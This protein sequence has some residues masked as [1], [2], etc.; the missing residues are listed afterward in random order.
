MRAHEFVGEANYAGNQ[1]Y[2]ETAQ[3]GMFNGRGLLSVL[4]CT[5]LREWAREWKYWPPRHVCNAALARASTAISEANMVHCRA[6]L[7]TGPRKERGPF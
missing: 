7:L 3:A 2:A 6:N 1:S 4:Y 5:D